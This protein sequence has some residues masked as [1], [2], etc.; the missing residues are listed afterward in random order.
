MHRTLKLLLVAAGVALALSACTTR[1]LVV[2]RAIT[3]DDRALV[4]DAKLRKLRSCEAGGRYDALSPGGY[5]RGAY[6]FSQST[7]DGVARRN[8]R[9][10]EGRNPAQVERW[11]Q[12]AMARALYRER[13]WSPWPYCGASL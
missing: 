1:E 13:G 3:A 4:S 6:Q 8:Y 12:D 11:W 10:L 5:Y 2:F 9:W 7:W